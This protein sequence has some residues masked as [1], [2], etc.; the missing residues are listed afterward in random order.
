MTSRAN[1]RAR[2]TANVKTLNEALARKSAEVT[3]PAE[4]AMRHRPA[5][6]TALSF[7]Q[8][9]IVDD[10]P[11]A[12]DALWRARSL[13]LA[14]SLADKGVLWSVR[15]LDKDETATSAAAHSQSMAADGEPL[16][17]WI[18]HLLKHGRLPSPLSSIMGQFDQAVSAARRSRNARSAEQRETAANNDAAARGA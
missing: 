11:A 12:F 6:V 3:V 13:G 2:I 18:A 1:E 14:P 16:P 15:R 8:V 17:A 4:P 5:D 7:G 9:V 10:A